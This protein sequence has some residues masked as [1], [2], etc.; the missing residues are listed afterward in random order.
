LSYAELEYLL[1]QAMGLDAAS[2]GSPAVVHAVKTRMSA[3]AT[4]DLPVY[5][6]LIRTSAAEKQALIEAIVVSETWFFRDREA[7]VELTR[8]ACQEWLP[9]HPQGTLRLL[10]V[11][12]SSG[13]EPYSMAMALLDAGFPANRFCIDA[14][15]ISGRALARAGDALYGKNSFRGADLQFRERYFTSTNQGYLLSQCVRE[16]VKFHQANLLAGQWSAGRQQVYDVIFCRNLVIYFDSATQDQA[17]NVLQHLLDE[18]GVLFV[19]PSEAGLL[20][21]HNFVSAKV[22][23]AFAFRRADK[24]AV[25]AKVAPVRQAR[26]SPLKPRPARARARLTNHGT[27]GDVGPS[28]D[29]ARGLADQGQWLEATRSCEEQLLLHGPSPPAFHLLGLIYAATGNLPEAD[30]YYRKALYLDPNHH[31]TLLHLALLLQQRGASAE[32]QVLRARIV[33]LEQK[34]TK[35]HETHSR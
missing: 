30:R 31:D 32:A 9:S 28:I 8:I 25:A 2:I 27:K 20:L 35:S 29:V 17:V 14:L 33:R 15:D 13:E 10:S 34:N 26:V 5:E 24:T 4:A 3:C 11:P 22:P 21:N 6:E 12:C 19:G 23:R 7:F 1:K 18:A 16:P